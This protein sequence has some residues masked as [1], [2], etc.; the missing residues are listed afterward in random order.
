MD[1]LTLGT[2]VLL[3]RL[4]T[5]AALNLPVLEI[6]LPRVLEGLRLTMDQFI[7]LCILS[8]CDYTDTIRGIGSKRA[9]ELVRKWGS[10]ESILANLDPAKYPIPDSFNF[11][12]AR[13]LF[14]S[15]DVLCGADIEVA[16]GSVDEEGLK[17]FL[18]TEKSFALERVERG[19][20]KLKKCRS[21]SVQVRIT[22]FFGSSSQSLS[23]SSSQSSP[24]SQSSSSSSSSYSSSS[25]LKSDSV[26]STDS[27][28][29]VSAKQSFF[30]PVAS[31]DDAF[32]KDG[33]YNPAKAAA[34]KR[35][36]EAAKLKGRGK[37]AAG[38]GASQAKRGRRF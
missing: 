14:R 4:T 37:T 1:A 12:G 30:C 29:P 36:A 25:E 20:E 26:K 6:H 7:D 24:S 32:T 23:Q 3:R 2:P 8:G 35:A 5:S 34:A 10:I 9:L 38:R 28:Q 27:S 17:E 15:P 21:K 19:I 33:F 11:E 22:E 13:E 16:W 31:A 18:V